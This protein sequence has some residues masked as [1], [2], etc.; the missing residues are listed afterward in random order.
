M[1]SSEMF[2]SVGGKALSII[3]RSEQVLDRVAEGLCVII[4][5]SNSTRSDCFRKS[6][7]TRT[8]HDAAASNPF[9]RYDPERFVVTRWNNQNFVAIEDFG[10]FGAAFGAG[11]VDLVANTKTVSELLQRSFFRTGTDDHQSWLEPARPKAA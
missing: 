4:R 3:R 1:K 7:A 9:Q 6:T 8:D 5:K 10:K 2:R 11:E